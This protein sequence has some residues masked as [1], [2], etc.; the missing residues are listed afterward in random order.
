MW[1]RLLLTPWWVRTL[2]A[3]VILSACMFAG[4]AIAWSDDGV[5]LPVGGVVLIALGCL[6]VGALIG[7]ALGRQ[8]DLYR[9][10]LAVT[11]SSA[12]RSE[13]INAVWRGPIPVNLRVREAALRLAQI[14]LDLHSKNRSMVLV[15]YPLL[16]VF[17]L[18]LTV[19]ALVEHQLG[20]A[21]WNAAIAALWAY[22]S[23]WTLLME[24][25][26]SNR[27]EKLGTGRHT[28]ST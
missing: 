24:K 8:R 11:S 23:V 5:G 14:Q 22:A 6:A 4:S 19:T 16:A 7:T 3:T 18:F 13:A 25:R 27:V 2:I 26:I 10:A 21:L 1:I 20:R 12:E 9:D 28:Q 17:S 15:V